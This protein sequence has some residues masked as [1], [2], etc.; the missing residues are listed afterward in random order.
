MNPTPDHARAVWLLRHGQTDWNLSRRYMSHSDRPLTPYGVM[1]TQATARFFASRKVDVVLHSGVSRTRVL[2]EAIAGAR[3]LPLVESY[4]WLETRHG[5]WEGLTYRELMKTHAAN[6]LAKFA[7][8][9]N[10][11]PTGGESLA[12]FAARI[13]QAWVALNEQYVGKR[14]VLV[15]HGGAIQV[16]LCLLL[17]TPVHTHWRWRIDLGSISGV[18]GYPGTTIVKTINT[19]PRLGG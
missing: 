18:D 19:V 14:V 9:L 1:Q 13:Q 16:L 8:P 4:G 2:A 7:D 15:T 5:A 3:K 6:A 11:A 12:T 17:N 10:T